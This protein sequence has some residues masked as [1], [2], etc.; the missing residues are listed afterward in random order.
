LQISSE[1]NCHVLLPLLV[2]TYNFLNPSDVGVRA[3]SSTTCTPKPTSLYDFME[4]NEEMA[5]SM[6]KNN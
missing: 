2:S 1:Y 5:L 3:S 6:V 4:T